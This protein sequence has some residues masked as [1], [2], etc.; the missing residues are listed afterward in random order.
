[1]QNSHRNHR[2]QI[3]ELYSSNGFFNLVANFID[4]LNVVPD[5]TT[6]SA[7]KIILCDPG[8]VVTDLAILV[9]KSM[10]RRQTNLGLVLFIM[11]LNMHIMNEKCIAQKRCRLLRYEEVWGKIDAALNDL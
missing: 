1:M 10:I 6:F 5:K 2:T 8:N 3:L 7:K 4:N 11:N 9:G